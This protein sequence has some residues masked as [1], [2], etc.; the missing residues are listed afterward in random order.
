MS[1]FAR[2]GTWRGGAFPFSIVVFPELLL[3]KISSLLS[4]QLSGG[5]RVAL[6]DSGTGFSLWLDGQVEERYN[7]EVMMSCMAEAGLT[8]KPFLCKDAKE[9]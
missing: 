7:E 2:D 5:M 8:E 1:I 9:F 3:V 6:S 4:E